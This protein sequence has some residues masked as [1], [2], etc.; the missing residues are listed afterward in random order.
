MKRLLLIVCATN[1]LTGCLSH[2]FLD[3]T[4]RMQIENATDCC[5]ILGL[6]VVTN[7]SIGYSIWVGEKLLPGERSHVVEDDWVGKF[8]LRL[9]YTKSKDGSGK[10]NYNYR[11]IDLDGGSLY[12]VVKNVSDSLYYR[13]K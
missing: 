3:S 1:L 2:W 9:R 10:V 6:D 4:S 8:K 7:D 12:M 13:F 5:T 11:K